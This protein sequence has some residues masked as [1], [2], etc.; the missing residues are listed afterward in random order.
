MTY[1]DPP[2][3]ISA[4]IAPDG[5]TVTVELNNGLVRVYV[6]SEIKPPRRRRPRTGYPTRRA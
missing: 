6:A 3:I 5:Q 2:R 4:T 1:P